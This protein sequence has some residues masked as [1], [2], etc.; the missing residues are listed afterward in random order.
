MANI[1]AIDTSAEWCSVALSLED[2]VPELRHE[3]VSAGASQL[4][5]P[6]IESLLSDG[7]VVLKDL[8]VIA[9]GVGPGA[10]TGVRLGVAAVQGLA[11]S[12]NIPVLPVCSLDAL[13]A[14]LLT[15]EVFKQIRPEQFTVAIDARMEEV[16]WAN[17]EMQNDGLPKRINE[18][19]LTRP[20]GVNLKGAEFLAG[21]AIHPYRNRLPAF[22]CPIH[23]DIAVSAL[24]ILTCAEQMLSDG[25]QCDV[26]LL[27]PLYVRN[28][29]AF[30]TAEREEGMR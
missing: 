4:L 20:E 25:L 13:A 23:S 19:Q 27:E 21:S 5:L 22:A 8:D 9:V 30:T 17:Y 6:W 16:Y 12:Q 1:L 14:Q 18:M 15:T 26:H 7:R 2:Q 24:G 29:V 11:I 28:K 3:R 10:F